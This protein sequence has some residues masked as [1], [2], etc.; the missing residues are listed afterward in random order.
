MG[1]GGGGGGHGG[2]GGRSSGGFGG[3]GRSS[4]MRSHSSSSRGS[5]SYHSHSSGGYRPPPPRPYYGHSRTVYVSDGYVSRR[6]GGN[7]IL[8]VIVALFLIFVIA[9]MAIGVIGFAAGGGV[10][11]STVERQPLPS[12]ASDHINDWYY[13]E[14][15][16][17]GNGQKSI[18]GMRYFE[19]KTGVQPFTAIIQQVPAGYSNLQAYAEGLYTE[20]Y[21]DDPSHVLF[22]WQERD[23]GTG[24]GNG[25]W[26]AWITVG[27]AA[28]NVVDDEAQNIIFDYF[29]RGYNNSS[30][31]EDELIGA[32]WSDA[33]DRMMTVT[34]SPWPR[35]IG[36]ALV[37]V[38][39]IV[40]FNVWVAVKKRKAKDRAEAAAILN[41]PLEKLD[42]S[43][44]IHGPGGK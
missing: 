7:S 28:R 36:I 3:S 6:S 22:V 39:I 11:R 2:G 5:S 42:A 23:D 17:I 4:S 27:G 16:W 32:M 41:T 24:N 18:A 43:E 13:D 30:W 31:S 14:W 9:S 15:M 35:V 25:S 1:R 40:V 12:S 44:L 20:I 29:E 21:G 34:K 8:G 37:I 26:N 10:T 33:A 38:L 19:Q